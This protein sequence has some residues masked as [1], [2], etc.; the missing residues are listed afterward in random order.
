MLTPNDYAP[1]AIFCEETRQLMNKIEFE[2]GGEEF[3]KA[4]PEGIPTSVLINTKDGKSF[5]SGMVKFPAGH[6]M[7]ENLESQM[8]NI[9]QHKIK[10]LGKLAMEQDELK[11][12]VVDLENI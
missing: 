8:K 5:D 6:A 9:M 4:Y 10:S 1:E 12:F 7:N 3:D 2:H 11:R